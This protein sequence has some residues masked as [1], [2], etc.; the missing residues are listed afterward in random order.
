MIMSVKQ[1]AP[2]RRVWGGAA[3]RFVELA[4]R[5]HAASLEVRRLLDQPDGRLGKRGLSRSDV[6]RDVFE[7][8]LKR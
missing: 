6:V 1:S 4:K 3:A 8:Y 7:R 2:A 5:A